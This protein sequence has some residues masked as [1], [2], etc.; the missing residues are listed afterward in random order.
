MKFTGGNGVNLTSVRVLP[1]QRLDLAEAVVECIQEPRLE[2]L[3]TI[4]IHD[5]E[6]RPHRKCGSIHTMAGQRV[7]DVGDG[8]DSALEWDLLPREAT[9]IA[10]P[11]PLFMVSPGDRG[12]LLDQARG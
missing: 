5:L 8:C 11:I 2:M 7:E 1:A 9:R 3:A 4:R 12:A 10:V 6:S